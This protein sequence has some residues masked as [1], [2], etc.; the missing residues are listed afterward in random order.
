[1]PGTVWGIIMCWLRADLGTDFPSLNASPTTGY[2][3]LGK[4]LQLS[5]PWFFL[6]QIGIMLIH[7]ITVR[8][9]LVNACQ[10]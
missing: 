1:M 7:G 6:F 4:L 10:V 3:E 5:V 8:I 9:K 2:E